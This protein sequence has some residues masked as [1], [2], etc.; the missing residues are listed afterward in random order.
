MA[1]RSPAVLALV[2]LIGTSCGDTH[3]SKHTYAAV[4]DVDAGAPTDAGAVSKS[5]AFRLYVA[6]TAHTPFRI[7]EPYKVSVT[8]RVPDASAKPFN[9]T[10]LIVE[11]DGKTVL[12]RKPS[13]APIEAKLRDPKAKRKAMVVW[14]PLADLKWVEGSKLSVR[15][16]VLVQG[17][18]VATAVKQDFDA[19]KEE[20]TYSAC[21]RWQML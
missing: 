4:P 1:R 17:E 5:G 15:A 14:V 13:D 8:R 9:L 19:T 3:Y 10:S 6:A 18:T 11:Q 16:E 7:G 2:V 21:E 20:R 12:A